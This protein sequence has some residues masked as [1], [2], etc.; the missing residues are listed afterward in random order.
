MEIGLHFKIPIPILLCGITYPTKASSYVKYTLVTQMVLFLVYT[1]DLHS[2]HHTLVLIY[3]DPVFGLR[4]ELD[5]LIL[6]LRFLTLLRYICVPLCRKKNGPIGI[7]HGMVTCGEICG[8]NRSRKYLSDPTWGL[9]L[10]LLWTEVPYT[11]HR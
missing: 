5:L 1:G 10:S 4:L 9:T 6:K 7:G 3:H 8:G 2:M 11:D